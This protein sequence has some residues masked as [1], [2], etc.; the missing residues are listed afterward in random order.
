[1]NLV[2]SKITLEI[3]LKQRTMAG[4]DLLMIGEAKT[5][6]MHRLPEIHRDPFDRLLVTNNVMS[7]RIKVK[8]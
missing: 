4:V 8:V 3:V 6:Q 7:R 5:C 2:H 1:M